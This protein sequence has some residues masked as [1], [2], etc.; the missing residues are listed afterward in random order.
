MYPPSTMSRPYSSA[1]RFAALD[2]LGDGTKP[3]PRP[4]NGGVD[5]TILRTKANGT[6]KN[7]G[8]PAKNRTSTESVDSQPLMTTTTTVRATTTRQRKTK[9]V[10]RTNG[11]GNGHPVPAAAAA[12][13]PID[14]EI[15][16]KSLHASI[17]FLVLYLYSLRPASVW[18]LIRTLVAVGTIIYLVDLLRFRSPGFARRYHSIL[19]A[20]MRESEKTS[21]NGVVWYLIGVTFTLAVYPRDIA[22]VAI[23]T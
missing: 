19:G 17:G 16:R 8:K 15:P 21:V 20:L 5:S 18:P 3:H 6:A 11:N 7:A 22:V 9:P 13:P 1:N 10:P 14:W 23:M 12:A 2:S 4:V